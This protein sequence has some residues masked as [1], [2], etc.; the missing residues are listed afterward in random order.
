MKKNIYFFQLEG[1]F[2]GVQEE[3]EERTEQLKTTTHTLLVTE[4]HFSETKKVLSC[5]LYSV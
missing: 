1:M 4:K 3:L 2:S 5:V